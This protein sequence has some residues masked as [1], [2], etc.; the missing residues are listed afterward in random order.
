MFELIPEKYYIQEIP[1]EI[2]YSWCKNIHYSQCI[3]SNI[4][5]CYGLFTYYDNSLI[6]VC[7]FG[8]GANKN[9]NHINTIPILELQRLILDSQYREKN[10]L[11]FFVAQCLRQLPFT[12][13]IISYA[14]ETYNH[15]GYIYQATNFIYTGHT[16][17]MTYFKHKNDTKIIHRKTLYDKFNT[18][19]QNVLQKFGYEPIITKPKHR[20]FYIKANNKKQR[21]EFLEILKTK[22]NILPYPKGTLSYYQEKSTAIKNKILF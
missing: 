13:F 15:Y 16:P 5:Y 21:K 14:D 7:I 4:Q 20:Y 12:G 17:N 10:I 6:G 8:I 1:K 2:T 18:S 11:S 19:N 22:Y 9:N 3:P